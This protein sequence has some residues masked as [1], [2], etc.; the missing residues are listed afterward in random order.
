M[1]RGRLSAEERIARQLARYELKLEPRVVAD[2]YQRAKGLMAERM[3]EWLNVRAEIKRILDGV[4]EGR[5]VKAADRAAYWAFA[6]ALFS[7]LRR[8]HWAFHRRLVKAFVAFYSTLYRLDEDTL[9]EAAS[10]LA[11]LAERLYIEAE[12]EK[13]EAHRELLERDLEEEE[14]EERRAAYKFLLGELE[15]QERELKEEL[16]RLS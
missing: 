16:A 5:G 15:E 1:G 11:P 8:W 6:L 10:R 14:D 12:L 7:R 2:R 9:K 3:K 4:F 13:L